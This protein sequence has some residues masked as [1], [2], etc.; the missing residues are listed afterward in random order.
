MAEGRVQSEKTRA[1]TTR[2]TIAMLFAV[3]I[4]A[5]LPLPIAVEESTFPHRGR[6]MPHM[7]VFDVCQGVAASGLLDEINEGDK[8]SF[9]LSPACARAVRLGQGRRHLR[10]RQ[11]SGRRR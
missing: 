3:L 9:S 7:L 8:V 6:M 1:S 5:G 10:A 2:L 11:V 4:P